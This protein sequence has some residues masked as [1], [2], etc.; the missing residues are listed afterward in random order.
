MSSACVAPT[1]VMICAGCTGML[2]SARARQHLAQAGI[3]HGLA[4]AQ[5]TRAA[6]ARR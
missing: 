3:A 5:R 6:L 4:V 2:R 1:V